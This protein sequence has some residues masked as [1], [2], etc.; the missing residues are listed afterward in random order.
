M[1]MK[2][3]GIKNLGITL[4]VIMICLLFASCGSNGTNALVGTWQLVDGKTNIKSMILYSD[5]TASVENRYGSIDNGK[6][7]ITDNTLKIL[8]PLGGEFWF[9]DNLVG[10]YSIQGNTLTFI[11]PIVDGSK[12]D[13]NIIF[14]KIK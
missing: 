7:E 6:W 4:V 13:S 11:S 3:S 9:T 14:E 5:G 1:I 2:K 8:G 10:E 12:I